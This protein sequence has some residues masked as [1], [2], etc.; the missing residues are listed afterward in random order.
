MPLHATLPRATGD[1]FTRKL[2]VDSCQLKKKGEPG[3]WGKAKQASGYKKEEK[4]KGKS[5]KKLAVLPLV[6]LLH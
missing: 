2:S 4:S 6:M 3:K 5:E 1:R